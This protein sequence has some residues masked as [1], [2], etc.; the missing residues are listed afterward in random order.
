MLQRDVFLCFLRPG[1][2][3]STT[4]ERPHFIVYV[5]LIRWTCF[6]PSHP[7]RLNPQPANGVTGEEEGSSFRLEVSSL[8]FFFVIVQCVFLGVAK[9][10][11]CFCHNQCHTI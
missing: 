2:D 9:P 3:Y 6:G 7:E 11:K 1:L 5:G 8:R 4:W 10:C